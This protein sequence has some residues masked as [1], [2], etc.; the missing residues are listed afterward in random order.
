M[1]L[2]WGAQAI[3]DLVCIYSCDAWA[4]KQWLFDISREICV[5]S[6]FHGN[7]QRTKTISPILGISQ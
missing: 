1:F 3:Q 4:K 2:M 5:D 7:Y 6:T